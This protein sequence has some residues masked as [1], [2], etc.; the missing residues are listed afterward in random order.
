MIAGLRERQVMVVDIGWRRVVQLVPDCTGVAGAWRNH[1][2]YERRLAVRP[3]VAL[4]NRRDVISDSA[5]G[6]TSIPVIRRTWFWVVAYLAEATR[7]SRTR[8]CSTARC[9]E[10]T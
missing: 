7:S 9:L 1:I 3:F 8:S 2:W 6:R 5:L 10:S 4:I